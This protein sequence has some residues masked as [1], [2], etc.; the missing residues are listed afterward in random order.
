MAQ[1]L[2]KEVGRLVASG[3]AAYGVVMCWTGNRTSIA[4]NK[5]PGNTRRARMGGMDRQER[6]TVE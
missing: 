5:V 2:A 6:A 1:L 3:E 4:A